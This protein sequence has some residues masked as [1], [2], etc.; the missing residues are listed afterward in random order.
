MR[1]FSYC[2][3]LPPRQIATPFWAMGWLVGEVGIERTAIQ[4]KRCALMTLHRMRPFQSLRYITLGLRA[5][6]TG[7]SVGPHWSTKQN[8][9]SISQALSRNA[10]LDAPKGLGTISAASAL[11]EMPAELPNSLLPRLSACSVSLRLNAGQDSILNFLSASSTILSCLTPFPVS[12]AVLYRTVSPTLHTAVSSH[13][14]SIGP[15]SATTASGF[16]L[17]A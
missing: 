4:T 1:L 9:S 15:A 10:K 16:L 2:Q 11:I 6:G 13:S 7:L 14:I 8:G 3:L 5:C 12:S 17:A